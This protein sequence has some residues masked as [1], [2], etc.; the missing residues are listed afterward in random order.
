[1]SRAP[2]IITRPGI[3]D[4]DADAYHSDPAPRASLSSTIAKTLLAKTPLHAWLAC[5]RLNPDWEPLN[6]KTFDIGRAAHREVLG[7]GG[8]WVEI[9]SDLLASNGA[10]TTKAAKE[11][12]EQTRAAGQTPIKP[13]EAETVRAMAAKLY[14]RLDIMGI[15]L[16]PHRSEMAAFAELDGIWCRC[17]L[18]NAPDTRRG[19]LYDLKTTT[20]ANPDK[21]TRAIMDYGYD[22]Q[23]QHYRETWK[24]ATGEDRPFRFIFVEKEPPYEVC[25]VE[26]TGE[27]LMMAERRTRRARAIFRDC[28]AANNWPGYPLQ[29]VQIKLPEFYQARWLEREAIEADYAAA[30]V[31]A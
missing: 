2:S 27:D 10:A 15:E 7:R 31:T 14:D 13:D 12:I 5:P 28:L 3:Y 25:V 24:A 1:M 26:L 30:C 19:P 23:A 18:D 22:V 17:L 20:D 8:E 6:K 16:E 4:L 11:F 9:P 29:V 21:I